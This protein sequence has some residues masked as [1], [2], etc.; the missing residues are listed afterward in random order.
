MQVMSLR[1]AL[2]FAAGFLAVPIFHQVIFAL[3]H[4][5]GVIPFLAFDIRPTSPLGVPA[6][7]SL[8]FWGGVWGIAFVLLTSRIAPG[9][10]FYWTNAV[11]FGAIAPTLVY[12][13]VVAP[14]TTG[15]L[16]QDLGRLFLIGSLLNGA[17]GVGTA[18]LLA[19]FDRIRVPAARKS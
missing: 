18:V 13:F 15:T 19:I 3:L 6:I 16:P 7:I 4:A 9:N 17:W 8:S 10:V 11:L 2:A 14:I 12:A 1:V 5:L